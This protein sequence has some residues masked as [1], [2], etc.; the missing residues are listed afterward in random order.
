[1]G[2]DFN[3]E[4]ETYMKDRKTRRLDLFKWAR[5]KPKPQSDDL[6][7]EEKAKLGAVEEEIETIEEAEQVAPPEIKEELEEAHES[8]L[9]RFFG[10]FRFYKRRHELE[11]EADMIIAAEETPQTAKPNPQDIEEIREV[12]RITHRWLGKLNKRFV[13]DFQ[14]SPDYEKYKAALVKY[15]L[16]KK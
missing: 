11:D 4:M 5:P 8:A 1:M 12:L 15:G 2:S 10:M 7:P 9:Q 16:A 14:A 13:D 3:R 6:T